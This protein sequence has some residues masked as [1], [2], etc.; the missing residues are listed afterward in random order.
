MQAVFLQMNKCAR[1]LDESLVK[2]SIRAVAVGQPQ[3]FQHVVR[4][5][6]KLAV[7]AVEIA[8]VMRV[9]FPSTE[10]FDHRGNARAF[11]THGLI[12]KRRSRADETHSENGMK[13]VLFHAV[14]Q[15]PPFLQFVNQRATADVQSLRRFRA[16][17]FVLPQRLHDCQPFNFIEFFAVT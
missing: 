12:L 4:L 3:I 15:F 16:V 14:S 2:I 17:G 6:K 10:G 9:E 1:K 5:V 13:K 11:V 7:E 8:E